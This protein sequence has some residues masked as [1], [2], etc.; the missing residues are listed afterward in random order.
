MDGENDVE[1]TL[2][3]KMHTL[4]QVWNLEDEKNQVAADLAKKEEELDRVV[5]EKV[6]LTPFNEELLKNIAN[7][8][9]LEANQVKV[10]H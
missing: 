9:E 4:L 5:I 2:L 6:Q 10:K 7:Y 1:A 8:G 3:C